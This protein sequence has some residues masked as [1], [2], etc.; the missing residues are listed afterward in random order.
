LPLGRSWEPQNAVTITRTIS[1]I[2]HTPKVAVTILGRRTKKKNLGHTWKKSLWI[3][4]REKELGMQ[5]VVSEG[6]LDIDEE[7]C[8]FFIV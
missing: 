6:N 7:F 8:T 4:K 3:L 1:L 5:K 2:P